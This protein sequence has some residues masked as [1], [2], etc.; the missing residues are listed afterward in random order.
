MSGEMS[1]GG[2]LAAA[3]LGGLL[4]AALTYFLRRP[5]G[6]GRLEAEIGYLTRNLTQA[7]TGAMSDLGQVRQGLEI[8]G[9]S[10]AE[11]RSHLAH[12]RERVEATTSGLATGL[13]ERSLQTQQVI[14]SEQAVLRRE[15]LEAQKLV[16]E[17]RTELVERKQRDDQVA[18]AIRHLEVV[19]A[20]SP[21]KGAAGES[22]LDEAFAGFPPEMIERNFT[23][24]GKVVEYALVLAGSNRR[25]PIDSKWPGTSAVARLA[26]EVDETVRQKTVNELRS[27]LRRKIREV[28]QY[29][30]PVT[31]TD[32]AIAAVPDAVYP[33]C[34]EMAFEAYRE[35]VI[36]M[37]YGMIVPYVLN[38][39]NLHLKYAR[40]IDAGRLETVLSDIQR[41]VELL[42]KVLEDRLHRGATMVGNA[43][44]DV[45]RIASQIKLSLECVR[46]L[47]ATCAPAALASMEQTPASEEGASWNETPAGRAG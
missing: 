12:L 46:A 26:E 40:S 23:V 2:L 45:R 27:Q 19:L 20:G 4:A 6:G 41:N 3:A 7:L 9:Q 8:L 35:G 32:K 10:Q 38:L 39:Y 1:A 37:P 21:S 47:P 34:G 30:D 33:Y 5:S 24:R 29:L 31:T 43:Y 13:A 17:V 36:I 16:Q 11:L 14:Q 28:A 42:D 25:M 15:V 22:I 44:D 18:R